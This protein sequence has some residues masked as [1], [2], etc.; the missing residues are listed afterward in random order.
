MSACPNINTEEWKELKE[1]V[2]EL[3]AYALF[4]END[5]KLPSDVNKEDLKPLS[6]NQKKML[7]H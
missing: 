4:I 7:N 6:I 2:G 1:N 5:Y 3:Q